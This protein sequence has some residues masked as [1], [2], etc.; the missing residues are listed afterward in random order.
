MWS[1][2]SPCREGVLQH[3][4]RT[5]RVFP[6][7][8]ENNSTLNTAI[9]HSHAIPHLYCN[10]SLSHKKITPLLYR[11]STYLL[12]LHGAGREKQDLNTYSSMYAVQ[13]M[14]A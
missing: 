9:P 12:Q 14:C 5:E 4:Q 2:P 7:P 1:D 13:Q 8:Q 6:V 3:L 11:N 10:C